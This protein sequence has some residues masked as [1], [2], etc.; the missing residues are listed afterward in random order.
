MTSIVNYTILG[1]FCDGVYTLSTSRMINVVHNHSNIQSETVVYRGICGCLFKIE[2]FFI[3]L[4]R[5]GLVRHM[6][7]PQYIRRF[8]E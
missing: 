4:S 2:S 3:H 1:H 5:T 6:Q 7:A 8:L